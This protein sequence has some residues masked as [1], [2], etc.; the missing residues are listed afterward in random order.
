MFGDG[1]P[2]PRKAHDHPSP[3]RKHRET[4]AQRRLRE[5]RY[6]DEKYREIEAARNHSRDERQARV[7]AWAERQR[8]R[9]QG[10]TQG[11]PESGD[12][13]VPVPM[14]PKLRAGLAALRTARQQRKG[15]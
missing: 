2:R 9:Q 1:I 13:P 10:R 14:F 5:R 15:G 7:D 4:K 12:V 11:E 8:Q 3:R 6:F